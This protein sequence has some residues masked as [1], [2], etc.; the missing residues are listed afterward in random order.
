[1]GIQDF[2]SEKKGFAHCTK[3]KG[4]TNEYRMYNGERARPLFVG[5][6]DNGSQGA[7]SPS[8]F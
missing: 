1:M 8:F 7:V 3:K 2:T 6:V 5:D 4:F